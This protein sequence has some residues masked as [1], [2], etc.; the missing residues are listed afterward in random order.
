MKWHQ[1]EQL[2]FVYDSQKLI[3]IQQHNVTII[4]RLNWMKDIMILSNNNKDVA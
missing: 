2:Y 1:N 3:Y 4:L